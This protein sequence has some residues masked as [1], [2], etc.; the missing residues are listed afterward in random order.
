MHA[1]CCT[2]M[3]K[4]LRRWT[5]DLPTTASASLP[6]VSPPRC[7]AELHANSIR[8]GPNMRS[9]AYVAAALAIAAALSGGRVLANTCVTEHL[10]CATTMPVDGYCECGAHGN[11]EGGTVVAKP[12]SHRQVN[13]TSGGCG[14]EPSAPGCR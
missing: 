8:K 3:S 10:M 7:L 9:F 5:S 11:T 14:A 13:A 4:I 2:A 12:R 1:I 6:I